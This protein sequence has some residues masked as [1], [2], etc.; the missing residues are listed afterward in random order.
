MPRKLGANITETTHD[1][2]A[3]S[4]VAHVLV[5]VNW[6]EVAIPMRVKTPVPVFVKVTV[7]GGL[8]VPTF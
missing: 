2:P 7:S 5:S 1:A 3:A 8:V 6:E 4:V